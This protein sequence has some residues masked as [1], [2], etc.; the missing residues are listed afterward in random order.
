M[1]LHWLIPGTYFTTKDLSR[2]NLASIRLRSAL[3]IGIA[4]K[5]GINVSF[6]ESLSETTNIDGVFIG[7]I[8]A[9]CNNGRSAKWLEYLKNF[10]SAGKVI[11][12]DYTDNHLGLPN[13]QMADF[14]KSALQYIDYTITPSGHMANLLNAHYKGKNN[15]I[16]DP[17]EI[18]NSIPKILTHG[19][20]KILWF[21]HGSNLQYLLNYLYS[22]SN[23]TQFFELL[24]LS[25]RASLEFLVRNPPKISLNLKINL[26]EWSISNMIAASKIADACIIPSDPQDPKKSG[27]SSN[28]LITSFALGLPTAA[29]NIPSYVPYSDYYFDL[30]SAEID[31]FLNSLD[32]YSLKISLAQ[33]I[34]TPNYTMDKIGGEWASFIK[35][36]IPT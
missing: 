35:H 4:E 1:R 9:D 33:A 5:S 20:K 11:I 34:V 15:I 26:A 36:H 25:D 31:D 6:G 30:Q 21:G 18:S 24:I 12:L 2:S 32:K 17:V 3:A 29:S 23:S 19:V 10:K 27:A 28:R 16:Y 22:Q 7:K 14:Y 8:G 13:S